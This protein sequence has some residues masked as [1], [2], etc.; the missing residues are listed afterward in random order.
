MHQNHQER[1]SHGAELYPLGEQAVVVKLG[2]QINPGIHNK[3]M[4]LAEHLAEHPLPGMVEAV[5]A[6]TTVTVYFDSAAVYRYWRKSAARSMSE[7]TA[8]ST[9]G[10]AAN[11]GA[12]GEMGAVMSP[13][14]TVCQW[15]RSRL[16]SLGLDREARRRTVEI[17][18]CYGGEYGPDLEFVAR[19]NGLDAEEVIRIHTAGEYLVYMIGFTPGFPYLGGLSARIAAPRLEKPR[20]KVPGG[21]VGIAGRQTGI[22]PL[23]APGGWRLIGR[24]PLSLFTPALDPPCLLRPGDAVT[25]KAISREEYERLREE[26]PWG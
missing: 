7:G 23:T 24:T 4:Q 18:V 12:S 17:P 25:F 19:H 5:P 6:Y 1:L 14:R 26:R 15:L 2:D 3:V 11:A 20:F 16:D 21:S 8:D 13:Y 22:Y 10:G 9:P